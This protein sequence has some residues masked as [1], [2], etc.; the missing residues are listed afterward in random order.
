MN[1]TLSDIRVLN[2]QHC[3]SDMLLCN[4]LLIQICF[5]TTSVVV[6]FH[7]FCPVDATV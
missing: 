2:K 4:W 3:S 7:G 1:G 5:E 6:A